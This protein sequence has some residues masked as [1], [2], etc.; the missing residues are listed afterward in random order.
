MQ[1]DIFHVHSSRCRHAGTESEVQYIE[2]AIELGAPVIWFTD[3]APFPGDPFRCR[4]KMDELADYIYILQEFKRRYDR[5][6]DIKIGLEIEYLP[7]FQDYYK[8]LQESGDF[9]IFL[10]GQHFSQFPDG[11]YS[12]EDR[13]RIAEPRVLADGMM[14]GMESGFFQVAA[15]PC[16]VFRRVKFWNEECEAIANEIK[17]C[18]ARTGMILEKNISNMQGKKKKRAYRPEFW[19][20]MPDDF[21]VPK[22]IYGLDAHSVTELEENY[23]I[24]LDLEF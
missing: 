15:H 10:L 4:M 16:Q 7:S 1:R 23:R 14:N 11:T 21:R 13:E 6:I 22:T 19:E 3:H 18:A 12:F 20:N 8:R 24:Q 5:R 17:E 9:D 2:K